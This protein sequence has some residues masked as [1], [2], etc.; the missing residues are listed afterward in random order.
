MT[1]RAAWV[2]RAVYVVFGLWAA[3]VGP[4]VP[5][6]LAGRGFDSAAIGLVTAGAAFI[7]VVALP[8]WG[9]LADILAGRARTFRLALGLA[10]AAALALILPLPIAVFVIALAS[11]GLF[12]GLFT[13]LVDALAVDALPAPERQY[14]ALRALTSLSFAIGVIVD[15][16]VYNWAGYGA[17]A[18]VALAWSAA[19]FLLVGRVVDRTRDADARRQARAAGGPTAPARLGSLGQAFAVQPRL[20]G[21]LAAYTLGYAGLQAGVTFVSL[22]I[23]ELG[24]RPSDVA[25]TFGISAFAEIP[26]LVLAGWLARRIGLRALSA[27]SLIGFGLC[28]AA[29]AF[30]DS[31]DA[32]NATRLGTG[33][34]FGTFTAT[35]VL[36]V[37]RLLPV[38]LQATGQGL[39]QVATVGVGAIL[40]SALGGIGYGS[41]GPAGLFLGAA[42]AAIGGGIW[43]ATVLSG[44]VGARAL[45]VIAGSPVVPPEVERP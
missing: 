35:R 4:F 8:A 31:P 45:P 36:L 28:I 17:A 20:L 33:L 37:G 29:W 12:L 6:I 19:L 10:G 42:A 25:L 24:G 39:L 5:V 27:A 32:I 21:I 22:R 11:F 41:L 23:V 9:H 44:P 34:C 15:G 7:L 3:A 43:A 18:F 38:E 30:L 40:G 1:I 13:A 26:G 14:G 2:L 16:F